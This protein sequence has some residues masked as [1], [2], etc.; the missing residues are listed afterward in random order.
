MKVLI[1]PRPLT[2]SPLTVK[3]AVSLERL[4]K[5]EEDSKELG[6]D[7]HFSHR[8]AS[9]GVPS[10]QSTPTL[11]T[12]TS[13]PRRTF[14]VTN[15]HRPCAAPTPSRTALTFPVKAI[16]RDSAGPN[17]ARAVIGFTYPLADNVHRFQFCRSHPSNDL[18]NCWRAPLLRGWSV[19]FH[20]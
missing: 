17:G 16:C 19:K 13:S 11:S 20:Y 6:Q 15:Q 9:L 5:T 8:L 3:A 4:W 12:Q 14:T 10:V 7:D 2:V 18:P 1:C